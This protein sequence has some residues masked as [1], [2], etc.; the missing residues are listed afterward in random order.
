M[1]HRLYG[2][3]GEDSVDH[4][5]A[6]CACGIWHCIDRLNLYSRLPLSQ[7][8]SHMTCCKQR[9]RGRTRREEQLM[10]EFVR[11]RRSCKEARVA[12]DAAERVRVAVAYLAL[13]HALAVRLHAFTRKAASSVVPRRR[14]CGPM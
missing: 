13:Q 8:I 10:Q 12:G 2:V 7:G 11:V 9:G 4:F 3:C 5:D 6:Q 14:R 1:G